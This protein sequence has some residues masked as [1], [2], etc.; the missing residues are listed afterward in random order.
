MFNYLWEKC[1]SIMSCPKRKILH[2]LLLWTL[3]STPILIWSTKLPRINEVQTSKNRWNILDLLLM[4]LD[5]SRF[6]TYTERHRYFSYFFSFWTLAKISLCQDLRLDCR[7]TKYIVGLS[8][9]YILALTWL[10]K[11]L[12]SE[13]YK[14]ACIKQVLLISHCKKCVK[15]LNTFLNTFLHDVA[16]HV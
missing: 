7:P 13:S 16:K 8:K 2:K 4:L 9:L 1:A 11:L 14:H 10:T 12:T 5:E 15:R 3:I 6:I